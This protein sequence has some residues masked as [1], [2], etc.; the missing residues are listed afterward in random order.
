MNRGTLNKQAALSNI[1]LKK[2]ILQ[3]W[4]VSL[5]HDSTG[6]VEYFPATIRQFNA[7]DLSQN[8]ELLRSSLPSINRNAND[9]LNNYPATRA[10][11]Q[12]VIAL[13]KNHAKKKVDKSSRIVRLTD[14]IRDLEMYI[15]V[16]EEEL[17]TL[18][19]EYNDWNQRTI[20]SNEK[21]E[22]LLSEFHDAQAL[23]QKEKTNLNRQNAELKNALAKVSGLQVIL[24]GPHKS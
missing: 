11:L 7:W 13:L 10:E 18:R 20:A 22:A 4:C 14:K 24:D 1:I 21:Y 12:C 23:A 9:T 6:K 2:E 5:P 3:S 16:L 17:I 8:S 15:H 19:L